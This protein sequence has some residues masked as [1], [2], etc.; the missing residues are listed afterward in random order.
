[1]L[2]CFVGKAQSHGC[3]GNP[4]K[5]LSVFPITG[6]GT[7]FGIGLCPRPRDQHPSRSLSER[8]SLHLPVQTGAG[9]PAPGPHALWETW[10]IADPT[11]L[12]PW[13]CRVNPLMAKKIHGI[14]CVGTYCLLRCP[15]APAQGWQ[16]QSRTYQSS[17]LLQRWPYLYRTPPNC[18]GAWDRPPRVHHT[19]L[20]SHFNSTWQVW[21]LMIQLSLDQRLVS[22]GHFHCQQEA[23]AHTH[24]A[25]SSSVLQ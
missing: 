21:V 11:C 19:T 9:S 5:V 6:T 12:L 25:K 14:L 13:D 3:K 22:T 20:H 17:I 7:A 2:A 4:G 15:W 10:L 1:M 8:A 24:R 16:I 18:T 23:G